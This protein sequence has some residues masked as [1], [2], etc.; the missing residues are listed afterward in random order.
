[1]PRTHQNMDRLTTIRNRLRNQVARRH[2][3]DH[4]EEREEMMMKMLSERTA[5]TQMVGLMRSHYTL[6]YMS[7]LGLRIIPEKYRVFAR[8]VERANG[9]HIIATDESADE[10]FHQMLRASD[11]F[12]KSCGFF[13]LR[14][15]GEVVSVATLVK[16][17][18]VNTITTFPE[19]RGKGY[20]TMLLTL[21]REYSEMRGGRVFSPVRPDVA[22]MFERAGWVRRRTDSTNPDGTIDYAVP[23]AMEH[24]PHFYAPE[25][26]D[27]ILDWLNS[28]QL[29]SVSSSF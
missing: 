19:H 9:N 6:D 26:T 29:L 28:L 22:P 25:D 8:K 2:L 11:D 17:N 4:P 1:M 27:I 7:F 18:K 24:Y 14:W 12:L 21:I 3:Q 16:S 23:H 15:K 13:I 5:L 20:G 10:C